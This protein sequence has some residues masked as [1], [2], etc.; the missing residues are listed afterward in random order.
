MAVGG[1]IAGIA[2]A[3]SVAGTGVGI[4]STLKQAKAQK[5]EI[6]LRQKQEG[7][8]AKRRQREVL[9]Q[10]IVQRADVEA[11]TQNQG[12]QG[13]SSESG[14]VG[15]IQNVA[16]QG[17]LASNQNLEISAGIASARKSAANAQTLGAIAPAISSFGQM[18]IQNQQP[19][20]RLG[21]QYFG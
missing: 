1:I 4:I 6:R 18:L 11:T 12:A 19:I 21:T 7:L 9:R 14:A 13:S 15:N 5:K 16:A 2:A 8:E 3:A 20:Q 17:I 10:S